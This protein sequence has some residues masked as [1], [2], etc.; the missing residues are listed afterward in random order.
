MQIVI[1][2]ND[3]QY[4]AGVYADEEESVEN[5]KIINCISSGFL[6]LTRNCILKDATLTIEN[7]KRVM[8]DLCDEIKKKLLE[9][10]EE[11]G[12]AV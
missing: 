4:E 11:E 7:K 2:C 8:S 6:G 3:N 12:A 10:I 9:A 5:D 1:K